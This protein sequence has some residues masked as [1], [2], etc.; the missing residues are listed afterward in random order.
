MRPYVRW[1]T[2]AAIL[3]YVRDESPGNR[4][5]E[6]RMGMLLHAREA[7][8]SVPMHSYIFALL[9]FHA[10]LG[11]GDLMSTQFSGVVCTFFQSY[12]VDNNLV[13]TCLLLSDV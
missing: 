11:G 13:E 3:L 5:A 8:G 6:R 9:V 1:I 7:D 4:F 10:Q 12:A 2:A